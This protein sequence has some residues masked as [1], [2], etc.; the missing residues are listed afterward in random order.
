[1]ITGKLRDYLYYEEE[2]IA[3]LKGDCLEILPLMEPGSVDLVLTDPPYGLG[4]KLNG[5]SWGATVD[6]KEV[7]EW[8][9]DTPDDWLNYI[10]A[11]SFARSLIIW[12]G[13]YYRLPI[14]RGW[15]IWDKPDAAPSM[16]AC[17]LA[18]TNIDMPT[19][20]FRYSVGGW[21]SE[22]VDHPT[23]KPL[24]LINWCLELVPEAKTILDPFSGSGT[25]LVAAKNQ[26]KKAVGIEIHEPY[27]KIAVERL[28]QE[29]LL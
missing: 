16:G 9:K 6:H 4:K 12:G 24:A 14:S 26:G 28:R 17:E 15:L 27:L 13:N 18:W 3:L 10:F 22:R 8:D 11:T 2:G 29:I 23:Q 25:S 20:R 1:M 7:L 19:K 21:T 5:G